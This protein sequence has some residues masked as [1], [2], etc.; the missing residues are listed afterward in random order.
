[1]AS[2]DN[3]KNGK[4]EPPVAK[5]CQGSEPSA[6]RYV[7]IG[8]F[9]AATV[10]LFSTPILPFIDLYN[11]LARYFVLAHLNENAVLHANYIANWGI[12]P[13]I[14]VDII[15]T[16][17]V[18]MLS[19]TYTAQAIIIVIFLTQFCGVL[20][21]NRVL[22]GRTSL[23]SVLLLVP[24]LYSFILNWGFINFLFGLGLVFASAAWWLAQRDRLTIALPVACLLAIAIF[25]AHGLCFAL[26][27]IL[28]ASLEVGRVVASG[29]RRVRDFVVALVPVISQAVIPVTLFLL[30]PLSS[31][32]GV[33]NAN[34]SVARLAARG[35]LAGRLW[36]LVCYRLTTIARVEEGPSL[37]L[38][39]LTIIF[40][41]ALVGWL[42]ARRRAAIATVAWPAIFAG[43]V[44]VVVVPPA[45]FGVG[46]VADRMPLFLALLTVSALGFVPAGERVVTVALAVIVAVRLI[47]IALGWQLYAR[48]FADFRRVAAAVPP[49]ALVNDIMVGGTPRETDVRRCAMYRPLLVSQY[50]AVAPLFANDTQ[51]PLRLAGPLRKASER[52]PSYRASG[53]TRFG[54]YDDQIIDAAAAGFQYL[55]VCNYDGLTRHLPGDAPPVAR[56]SRFELLRI[57]RSP[58][59]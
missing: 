42:I 6:K 41:I 56:S 47:A 23:I 40:Q 59:S 58:K 26:Y 33:T 15:G 44:L 22:T 30:A 49:G 38:D 37:W 31:S 51:Q 48:D 46:Y 18:R 24:L 53:E 21:F 36:S 1:M 14:G 52:M 39:L 43:C 17:M 9:V 35:E 5:Y 29:T 12:L 45:L 7:I 55:L 32:G 19:P 25:F 11:H 16:A 50:G 4:V 10:P 20:I 57:D 8:I 3:L 13:N 27:G 28:V 34:A 54:F 2:G